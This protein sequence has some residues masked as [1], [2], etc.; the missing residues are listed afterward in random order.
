[1]SCRSAARYAESHFNSFIIT[2]VIP[3][4]QIATA[5]EIGLP[6]FFICILVILR[7]VISSNDDINCAFPLAPGS[8]CNY[9][10]F[11]PFQVPQFSQVS[12]SSYAPC[13]SFDLAYAPTY[14]FL[15][16]CHER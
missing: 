2:G 9:D 10:S 12:Q 5:F 16:Y 7:H 15:N 13:T 14:D 4:F 6:T 3:T 1:M 8:A 11:S